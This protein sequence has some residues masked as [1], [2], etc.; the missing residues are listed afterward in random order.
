M[1]QVNSNSTPFHSNTMYFSVF[2]KLHYEF[3]KTTSLPL[4]YETPGKHQPNVT[5]V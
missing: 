4:K 2:L 1:N 3:S 5:G